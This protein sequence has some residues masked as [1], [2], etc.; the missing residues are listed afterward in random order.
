MEPLIP[1]YHKSRHARAWALMQIFNNKN[2]NQYSII[3]GNTLTSIY[4]QLK[5]ISVFIFY[6]DIFLI[7][8]AVDIQTFFSQKST[9]IVQMDVG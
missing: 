3:H 8:G 5:S 1:K 7:F 6:S 2:I 9:Y 4:A